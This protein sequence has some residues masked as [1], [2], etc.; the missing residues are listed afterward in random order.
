MFG[1]LLVILGAAV[2]VFLSVCIINQAWNDVRVNKSTPLKAGIITTMFT[3][4]NG[5]LVYGTLLGG[6]TMWSLYVL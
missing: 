1:L 3:A 6:T 2:V 5:L 4:V